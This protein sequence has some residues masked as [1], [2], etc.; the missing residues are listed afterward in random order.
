MNDAVLFVLV[1]GAVTP[2]ASPSMSRRQSDGCGSNGEGARDEAS[3][4][5]SDPTAARVGRHRH[6][7][8]PGRQGRKAEH[9]GANAAMGWLFLLFSASLRWHAFDNV[10]TERRAPVDRARGLHV[11]RRVPILGLDHAFEHDNDSALGK[12]AGRSGHRHRLTASG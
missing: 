3:A 6:S 11:F 9:A 12:L 5:A 7:R 10:G 1:L 2:R 8:R 4:R